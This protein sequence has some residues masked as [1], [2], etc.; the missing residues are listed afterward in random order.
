MQPDLIATDTPPQE[1]NDQSRPAS[2]VGSVVS[3]TLVLVALVALWE[4]YKV[5]ATALDTTT[6]VRPDN[7]TMPHVWDMFAELFQPARRGGQTLI[8]LLLEA[9]VFTVREAVVGFAIGGLIGFGLGV[10][11][12][13]SSLA[14]RAF[15][16]YV[17]ASQT[18]PLLAIAPMVVIWGRQLSW[19]A[20]LSVSVIAAYLTFFPVAINTLRG[21]RSPDPTAVELMRSYAAS[22]NEVLWKL[23]VPAALPYIFT[24]LKVSAT[25]SII[26]ALIG[27][28]PG[29]VGNGLGRVLLDFSQRFA[30]QSPKLYATV[31]VT[32]LVGIAFVGAVTF[33]ERRLISASRRQA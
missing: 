19:P 13:R 12:V 16:P 6:P 31:I 8:L 26:G 10:L 11:F 32:C 7:V 22:P 24:A 20:W 14:E 5:V 28:L 4:L 30:V 1:Q 27:E 33:A 15:M 3:F 9:S 25:A 2:K 23:R 17:V 18:V 21:L 29:S